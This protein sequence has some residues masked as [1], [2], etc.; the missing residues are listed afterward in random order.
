MLISYCSSAYSLLKAIRVVS[1]V[2][3][4][5]FLLM[6]CQAAQPADDANQDFTVTEDAPL[7][8]SEKEMDAYRTWFSALS[9]EEKDTLMTDLATFMTRKPAT[10]QNV[11]SKF[12]P[13]Y[14]SYYVKKREEL[15]FVCA[16]KIEGKLFFLLTS[17]GT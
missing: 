9:A 10:A 12:D 8:D 7:V 1:F 6:S 4:I 13:M 2:S 14:R 5:I 11:T 15:E 16:Q 3:A 17:G